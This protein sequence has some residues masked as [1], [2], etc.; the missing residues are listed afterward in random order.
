RLRALR[1][2]DWPPCLR[3]QVA[4]E[5]GR[6]DH[7]FGARPALGDQCE[8]L[9]RSRRVDPRVHRQG[10]RRAHPDR[11]RHQAPALVARTVG[12]AFGPPTPRRPLEPVAWTLAGVAALA[13]AFFAFRG[14]D[15]GGTQQVLFT[16]PIPSSIT[17]TGQ[18][19]ISPDGRTIAF[20]AQDSLNRT[21]IWLRPL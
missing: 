10:S 9:A 6:I 2:G 14:G 3:R 16:V 5:P 12:R 18:P 20:A 19:R 11:A 13:A 17:P 7:E 1:D 4:G 8:R 21:M 15:S